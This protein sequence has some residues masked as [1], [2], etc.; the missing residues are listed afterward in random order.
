VSSLAL[1]KPVIL[2]VIRDRN[3]LYRD[4]GRAGIQNTYTI[5][6]VNK[7]NTPHDYRLAVSGIEGIRLESDASLSVAAESVFT[8]P[9][10]VTVPHE[11]AGGGHAIAFHLESTDGSDIRIS[12]ESR[13]RGPLESL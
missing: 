11:Y 8:L 4:V 7:H 13:F 5:R 6:V 10:S 3:A 1:T 9:V 2:D 12:E